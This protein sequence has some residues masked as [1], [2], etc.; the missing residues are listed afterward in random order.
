MPSGRL[1]LQPIVR[2]TDCTTLALAESHRRTK[3]RYSKLF[4]EGSSNDVEAY[5]NEVNSLSRLANDLEVDLYRHSA[6]FRKQHDH[7]NVSAE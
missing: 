7:K 3:F 6:S 4:V 5:R 1:A 2:E